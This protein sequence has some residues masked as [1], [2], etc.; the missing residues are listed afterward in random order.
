[1][2]DATINRFETITL[3]E[4]MSEDFDVWITM[5]KRFGFDL[6]I[7]DEN[8]DTIIDEKGIHPLAM[9]SYADMCRRFLYF[10]D[11]VKEKIENEL[12]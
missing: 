6:Q 4:L 3:S 10:Y 2:N 12:N 11:V 1:M 7:D 9:D 5:N 8:G